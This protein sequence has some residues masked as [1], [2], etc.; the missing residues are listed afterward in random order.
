MS[1]AAQLGKQVSK[2]DLIAAL[3]VIDSALQVGT[4]EQFDGLMRQMGTV[5]PIERADVCV[6]EIGTDQAINR[7]NRRSSLNYP[8]QW[9][10]VYRKRGY[11]RID[12]VARNLFVEQR[13]IF[14]SDLRSR[15]QTLVEQEFYGTAADF[16][17]KDGVSYGARFDNSS[18]GSF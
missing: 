9:V 3:D 11:Q 15:Y 4:A 2:R 12:P 13:P 7:I 1:A 6:V 18:S 8:L 17:L 16:G 14:W 10:G 5:L